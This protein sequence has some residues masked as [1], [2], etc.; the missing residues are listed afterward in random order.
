MIRKIEAL[1]TA[2]VSGK[3]DLMKEIVRRPAKENKPAMPQK[4]PFKFLQLLK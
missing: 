2:M 4:F 3:T 1:L